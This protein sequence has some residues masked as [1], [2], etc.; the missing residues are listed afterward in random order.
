MNISILRQISLKETIVLIFG[1][2]KNRLITTSYTIQKFKTIY[3]NLCTK[4]VV[5]KKSKNKTLI[6]NLIID[7]KKYYLTLRRD[8]S[9]I[10]VLKQVI[11]EEEY[12]ILVEY[13]SKN[14]DIDKEII[15]IDGGANVG[16]TSVFFNKYFPK[17]KILAIEPVLEN[18]EI[19]KENFL[20][21]RISNFEILNGG[22]HYEDSILLINN[23]FRDGKSWSTTLIQQNSNIN[24]QTSIDVF[25]LQTIMKKYNISN[26]DILKLDIEGS[27]KGL[28]TN[29]TSWLSYVNNIAIEI[30]EE[31]IS[32][33]EV[34]K[35]LRNNGFKLIEG[36]ELLFGFRNTI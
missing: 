6:S 17:A 29:D 16:Y 27:E 4:G 32:P 19:L 12:K 22:I 11:L 5:F 9:D 24:N 3:D 35:I 14:K 30:H 13:L 18:C 34:K 10:E 8:N 7:N 33:N 21:N 20:L 23:K 15:I 1:I 36:R 25:S 2:L 26:I 28:F 31:F